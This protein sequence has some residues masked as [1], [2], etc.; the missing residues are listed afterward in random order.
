MFIVMWFIF[1][2]APIPIPI[3]FLT[4]E[5]TSLVIFVMFI[6]FLIACS[7]AISLTGM[8]F[9]FSKFILE[10]YI[11]KRSIFKSSKLKSYGI[12]GVVKK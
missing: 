2:I 6:I 4:P 3:A 8:L 12:D 10:K 5:I 7:I 11:L 1:L 9:I